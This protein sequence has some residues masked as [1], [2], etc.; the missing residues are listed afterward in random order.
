MASSK[1]NACQLRT[2]LENDKNNG[3]EVLIAGDQGEVLG[4]D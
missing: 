1:L 4:I 3:G 2:F